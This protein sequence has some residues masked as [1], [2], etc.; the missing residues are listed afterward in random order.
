MNCRV[1]DKTVRVEV[2]YGDF[3]DANVYVVHEGGSYF[4]E[5]VVPVASLSPDDLLKVWQSIAW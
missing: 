2:V 5:E 1:C 3:G 4:C